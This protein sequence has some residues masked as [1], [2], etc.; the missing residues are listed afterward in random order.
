MVGW[1][2]FRDEYPDDYGTIGDAMLTLFV[3]LSTEDLPRMVEQGLEVSTWTV[4]YYVSFVLI[5][6]FLLLNIFIG[7]VINSMEEAREIEWERTQADR[8]RDAGET[9][10]P[11]DDQRVVLVDRLHSL[12]RAMEELERELWSVERELGAETR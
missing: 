8:R 4:L 12:R 2:I 11:M 7:V 1:L 10:Q 5:A 3:L 6:A 9:S